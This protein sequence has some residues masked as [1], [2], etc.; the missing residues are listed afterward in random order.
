M[1]MQRAEEISLMQPGAAFSEFFEDLDPFEEHS[2]SEEL[3]ND[4][5]FEGH[6]EHFEYLQKASWSKFLI[7]TFL[8]IVSGIRENLMHWKSFYRLH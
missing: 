8:E 4:M 2:T 5:K 6:L 3:G 1:R 7:L